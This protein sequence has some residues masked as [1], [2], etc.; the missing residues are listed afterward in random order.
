MWP[1]LDQVEVE[2]AQFFSSF[3]NS[4]HQTLERFQK[5][6]VGSDWDENIVVKTLG[7]GILIKAIKI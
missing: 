6:I 4:T 3:N 7:L 2:K 5:N 1:L